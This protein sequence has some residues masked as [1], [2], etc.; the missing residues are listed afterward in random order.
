MVT[1]SS[2]PIGALSRPPRVS[3]RPGEPAALP[4]QARRVRG[5]AHTSAALPR[6]RDGRPGLADEQ[7]PK[8]RKWRPDV[9]RRAQDLLPRRAGRTT[10]RHR[11]CPAPGG[12]LPEQP[13]ALRAPVPRR[14]TEARAA[15]ADQAGPRVPELE[16]ELLLRVAG[17]RC[18]LLYRRWGDRDGRRTHDKSGPRLGE[19]GAV[20]ADELDDDLTAAGDAR[21][22]NRLE[23]REAYERDG[24]GAGCDGM[25]FRQR[26]AARQP[27]NAYERVGRAGARRDRP[28]SASWSAR[29]ARRRWLAEPRCWACHFAEQRQDLCRAWTR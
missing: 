22:D 7:A 27:A 9:S 2:R 21:W 3:F 15:G 6:G 10:A 29:P 11:C 16:A 14:A 20:N 5:L 17:C 28:R 12:G 18:L 25:A 8:D 26:D 24:P 4:P 23:V 19:H 1:L 13:A